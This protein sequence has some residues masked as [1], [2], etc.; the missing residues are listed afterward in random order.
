MIS[1][2][3]GRYNEDEYG[4]TY[5]VKQTSCEQWWIIGARSNGMYFIDQGT[6]DT[7]SVYCEFNDKGN[8]LLISTF[9][10]YNYVGTS[11]G[12]NVSS[13]YHYNK[14]G[15]PKDM[16]KRV[17]K[18][19]KYQCSQHVKVTCYFHDALSSDFSRTYQEYFGE[20]YNERQVLERY[21]ILTNKVPP[22]SKS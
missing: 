17:M 8:T 5:S 21:L 1:D 15:F 18:K 2:C 10:F 20:A 6:E 4:C 7:Y 11:S 9:F 16:I 22:F 3:P 13:S 14:V 12:H 19:K